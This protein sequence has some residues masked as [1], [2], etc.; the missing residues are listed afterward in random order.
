MNPETT[1]IGLDISQILAI[2]GLVWGLARMSKAVDT[3]K[4]VSDKAGELLRVVGSELADLSGRVLVL[5]DRTGRRATDA[6]R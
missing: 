3:L 1:R 6:R 2:G 4:E 5:E